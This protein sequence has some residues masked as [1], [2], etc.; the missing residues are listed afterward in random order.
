MAHDVYLKMYEKYQRTVFS[1]IMVREQ[2]HTDAVK[3]LPDKSGLAGPAEGKAV[4]MFENDALQALYDEPIDQRNVS[5]VE[6]FKVGVRIEELDI[7]D[8]IEFRSETGKAD[9]VW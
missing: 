3:N 8:L 9:N 6:A 5:V 2:R 4:G 7:A 1:N